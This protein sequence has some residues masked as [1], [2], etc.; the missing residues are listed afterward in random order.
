MQ[1]MDWDGK[2]TP[3][4]GFGCG[5]VMG[6]V[7]R[8]E[9]LRAMEAAW[10]AGIRLFD[11]AR[12]YGYGEAEGL[13]GE[14]LVGR[15]EEAVVVT[16][17]GIWPQSQARWKRVAKPLVR[18]V[19]RAMPSARGLVRRAAAAE[20]MPGLF[21]VGTLRRSLEASLRALRTEYVD[22]LLAHEAPESLMAQEDLMAA[23]ERLVVEGKVRRLGVS[24]TPEVAAHGP[25]LLRVLQ[26]PCNLFLPA[27][28]VPA[29]RGVFRMVN[30]PFGGEVRVKVT[31]AALERLAEDEEV[32]LSLRSKLRGNP[33]E[34]LAE[35]VF[36]VV[37][38]EAEFV[39][40][41]M[42]H[43]ENL[44]ANVAGIEGER[45]SVEELRILRLRLGAL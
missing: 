8:R 13:L 18:S 7:G 20:T 29:K 33:L 36:G 37:L 41:S 14:F 17:F 24:A 19:L 2:P 35:V 27:C 10:E 26:F 16:K 30:H 22:A 11:T 45:F 1:M 9:S 25:A 43:L 21:D 5:S 12:S 42:L 44:R 40:P 38:Q 3:R 39:V 4:L 32:D 31:V 34:L 15:R 6:R 28:A 23:M